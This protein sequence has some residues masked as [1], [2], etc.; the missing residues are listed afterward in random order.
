MSTEIQEALNP[1]ETTSPVSV[2]GLELRSVVKR[3]GV[4]E[5]VRSVD[6]C[7]ARGEFLTVLGP[8]GSGKTTVLRM[9]SGFTDLTGG[10]ILLAGRDVSDM[11]P[12]ER[13]IGMVFQNYA[14]FPHLTAGENVEYGLKMRRWGKA[15][16]VR[17]AGEMLDLVGLGGMG[18]RLPREL[19]GGQQQ[20][21]A[22]ARALA[23]GPDLL[24][25]DEPLGALDRELRIRMSGELR[26][27]HAELGTTVVYVTHD[28]EEALTLSDRI[29]I[30]VAGQVEAIDT[31]EVLFT[32]PS[33]SFVASFFGGH[34]LLPARVVGGE[35]GV[36]GGLVRAEVL[37][38]VV[39]V[40]LGGVVE[41]GGEAFLVVPAQAIGTEPVS[42]GGLVMGCRVVES[43]YMGESTQVRVRPDLLVDRLVE[44][45]TINAHLPGHHTTGLTPGVAA[46]FVVDLAACSLVPASL[47]APPKHLLPAT[48]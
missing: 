28:R 31:P 29:A 35:V 27:I 15:D 21:V 13:G 48:A 1:V 45:A 36:V 22:L 34:N 46:S 3:Y 39:S 5:A 14:L 30:M 4:F 16:R 6:L 41:S 10:Q 8:S 33:S 26:R 7:V 24:L 37:G 11:S 2:P 23:F 38:Q 17:R 20:R 12:A 42:S 9:V 44:N 40:R 32:A 19:S 18:G 25:M 47:N 43:L